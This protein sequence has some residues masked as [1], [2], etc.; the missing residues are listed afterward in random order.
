MVLTDRIWQCSKDEVCDECRKHGSWRRTCIRSI[1]ECYGACYFPSK[2]F[3]PLNRSIPTHV[4]DILTSHLCREQVETLISENI[5]NFTDVR[6]TVKVTCGGVF[7]PMDVTVNLFVNKTEELL[8]HNRLTT[9]DE[10]EEAKVII[11]QSAPVGFFSM[12]ED[13]QAQCK[14][15]VKSMISNQH[16]VL[17][18]TAGDPTT[19]C[20]DVLGV[21][22]DYFLKETEKV[23]E[24]NI[25]YLIYNSCLSC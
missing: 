22:H 19:V 21:V 1:V 4:I 16:Y 18:V 5:A 20:R 9:R 11:Q 14:T 24:M 7:D 6:T 17:Q 13:L 15:Y 10:S 8:H 25:T 12:D 3:S 2:L 23:C